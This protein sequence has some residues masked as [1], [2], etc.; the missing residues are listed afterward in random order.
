MPS[1]FGV[2][3]TIL[4]GLMLLGNSGA[5]ADV[6]YCTSNSAIQ[7]SSCY[8]LVDAV[9]REVDSGNNFQQYAGS[10]SAY[11]YQGCYATWCNMNTGWGRSMDADTFGDAIYDILDTCWNNQQQDS[12]AK[13]AGYR[14]LDGFD[15]KPSAVVCLSKSRRPSSCPC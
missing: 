5:L 2:H 3:T 13:E 14:M 10:A 12:N 6:T 7:Y 4:A 1:H 8:N 15:T 11:S 9:R